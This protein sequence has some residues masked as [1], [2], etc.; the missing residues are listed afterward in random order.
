M[1]RHKGVLQMQS[2]Y[3]SN[4]MPDEINV[5]VFLIILIALMFS[6]II[7]VVQN[8]IIFQMYYNLRWW[9][10]LIPFYNTFLMYQ[11][12]FGSGWIILLLFV[13]IANFIVLIVY[14]WKY[15]R[16]LN[17]GFF[18]WIF[19]LVLPIF[20]N[21]YFIASSKTRYIGKDPTND[22]IQRGYY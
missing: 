19:Y 16:T 1:R 13:P 17:H 5:I 8:A 12:V 14:S 18:S 7:I 22:F 11:K 4:P 6:S 15:V 10:S 20:A 2:I 9:K 3:S 21:L